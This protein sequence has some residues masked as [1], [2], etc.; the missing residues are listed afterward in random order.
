MAEWQPI[1]TAPKDGSDILGYQSAAGCMRVVR[2]D[3][4]GYTKQPGWRANIHSFV[5]LP[6]T[7]WQPLPEPPK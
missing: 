2:W 3:D 1:D 4:G 5:E 6:V 7:H